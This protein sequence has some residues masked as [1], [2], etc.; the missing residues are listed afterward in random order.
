MI[1]KEGLCRSWP[2]YMTYF[3]DLGN[4]F[5][6]LGSTKELLLALFLSC[7]NS[8]T[9]HILR[10]IAKYFTYS[11]IKFGQTEK[12]IVHTTVKYCNILPST[13]DS[14]NWS[15]YWGKPMS[16]SHPAGVTAMGNQMQISENEA[17]RPSCLAWLLLRHSGG[18]FYLF[19]F[20][21]DS[22]LPAAWKQFPL[23]S[24][25]HTSPVI[26]VT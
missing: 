17:L 15:L 22:L 25:I 13:L 1:L 19:P 11:D 12:K 3:V 6:A 16:S 14:W 5:H 18:S 20:P 9:V 21:E 24:F 23:T 8:L 4:R 10:K 2:E 26:F 7:K